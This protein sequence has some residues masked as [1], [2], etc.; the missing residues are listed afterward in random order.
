VALDDFGTGY[1]SLTHLRELPID[2]VKIDPL[3]CGSL[4]A[5]ASAAAIIESVTMLA[6]RLGLQVVAEGVETAE[7]LALVRA[8]GC[9]IVPGYYFARPLPAGECEQLLRRGRWG[10]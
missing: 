8:A 3:D 10:E 5:D 6:H 2:R 9:D 7:Q 4:L 1:S